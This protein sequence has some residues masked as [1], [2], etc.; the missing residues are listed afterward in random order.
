MKTIKQIFD[1]I[2]GNNSMLPIDLSV[3][4]F[5]FIDNYKENRT[6]IDT[7]FKR[8][9]GDFY[10]FYEPEDYADWIGMISETLSINQP[11][12]VHLWNI[13][14]QNY[15]PIE[16]VEENTTTTTERIAYTDT[17]TY[18]ERTDVDNVGT[19][20]KTGN[21]SSA[22]KNY[23]VPFDG[24]EEKEIAKNDNT[25]TNEELETT[26]KKGAQSDEHT[27]GDQKETVTI[28]RH[29]NIGVTSNMELLTQENEFWQYFNFYRALFHLIKKDWMVGVL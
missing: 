10:V 17:D 15:V 25:V 18:G 8:N 2:I 19:N 23:S 7:W 29:G 1:T 24:T 14:Q 21:T 27:H 22:E 16:N 26:T 5:P 20:G 28:K 12:I 13:T 6:L 9:Y 4:N 3:E 11:N